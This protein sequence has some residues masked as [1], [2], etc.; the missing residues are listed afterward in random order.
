MAKNFHCS[1]TYCQSDTEPDTRKMS[2][3]Y[4]DSSIAGFACY[5][6]LLTAAS[7]KRKRI[8]SFKATSVALKKCCSNLQVLSK[9][10]EVGRNSANVA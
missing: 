2:W 4:L 10:G 7:D 8:K 1:T 6:V 5:I 9:L 3:V